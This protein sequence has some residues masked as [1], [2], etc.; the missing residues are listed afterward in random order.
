MGRVTKWWLYGYIGSYAGSMDYSVPTSGM[1]I[2]LAVA[3][4]R[5]V[6]I[7]WD[8]TIFTDKQLKHNR[9]DSTVVHEDIVTGVDTY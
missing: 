5:E 7:T 1:T 9:P 3:E 4:Y 8:M 6:R 2:N